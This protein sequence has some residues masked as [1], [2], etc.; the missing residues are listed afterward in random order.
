M[1]EVVLSNRFKK[2]LKLAAKR[3]YNLDLLENVVDT[4]ARGEKLTEKYRDHELIGNYSGFRECHIQPDWLLVYRIENSELILFL[5]R[6]GT[7]S[8]LFD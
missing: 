6:T 4:L 8:D 7:H 2:D 1:L 3:G 5:S